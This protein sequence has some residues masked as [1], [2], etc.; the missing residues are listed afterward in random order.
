LILLGFIAFLTA[1]ERAGDPIVSF[2]CR[3]SVEWAN[4]RR[5]RGP[6][7]DVAAHALNG[8][9]EVALGGD[10]AAREDCPRAPA[11]EFHDDL[12]GHARPDRVP[13]AGAPEIV[14]HDTAHARRR[15]RAL[16]HLAEV[17]E[18]AAGRAREHEGRRRVAG[19]H[20]T[21][22]QL[23]ERCGQREQLARLFFACAARR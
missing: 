10:V 9:R 8:V 15:A 14:E 18:P 11:A 4:L 13:R 20:A 1:A 17:A 5:V 12:L 19:G 21:L 22:D 23:Q 2:L 6:I 7:R 16:P 3:F